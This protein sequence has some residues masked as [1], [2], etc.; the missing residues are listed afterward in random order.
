[1][2]WC[3]LQSFASTHGGKK[4][5]LIQHLPLEVQPL[6]MFLSMIFPLPQEE[7][8]FI[9]PISFSQCSQ[10]GSQK[11]SPAHG[12]PRTSVAQGF[13]TVLRLASRSSLQRPSFLVC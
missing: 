1:M 2:S 12:G 6:D 5:L 3:H 8:W 7:I 4:P 9:P 10:S 13:I 11:S